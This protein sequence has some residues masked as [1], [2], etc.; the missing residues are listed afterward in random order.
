[1]MGN[2]AMAMNRGLTCAVASGL[3]AAAINLH[4]AAAERR[5][6]EA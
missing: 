2:D 1:M 4:A 3:P 5:T 6:A